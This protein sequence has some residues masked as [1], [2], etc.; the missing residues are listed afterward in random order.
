MYRFYCDDTLFFMSGVD[1]EDYY[2]LDAKL[3]LEKGK[4]GT[5]SFTLPS[6]NIAYNRINK[7]KSIITVLDNDEEIFRGRVL[8]DE[9]D[10]YNRKTIT[11]EGELAFLLD[12]IQRPYTYQGSINGFFTNLINNHN[13]QVDVNKKF[14]VG[15]ITVNDD[16]DYINR[17]STDY[18]NTYNVITKKL[19]ET[20]GG[21]LK[22][23]LVDGVRYID[24]LEEY[25]ETNEQVIEFGVN[26]LDIKEFITAEDIFT[27]LIPLGSKNEDTGERLTIESVNSGR[28]YL[29]ND[30]AIDLFGRIWATNTWE[31]VTVA[32]NL[33]TKAQ[34]YLDA[35]IEMSVT[36]TLKAI[37]LHLMNVNTDRI[38]EGDKLRVI[39]LPH[40]IDKYF[41]CTKVAIN[42]LDPS[43]NE[44]TFGST[45][46]TLTDPSTTIDNVTA[47]YVEQAITKVEE[48]TQQQ[49]ANV[50]DTLTQEEIMNIITNNGQVEGVY[51]VDG[52]IWINATYI[53]AEDLNA[54]TGKFTGE[55][56]AQSGKIGGIQIS[57]G[58]LVC[59]VECDNEDGF[60]TDG[61][62]S[63]GFEISDDACVIL[64]REYGKTE[65]DEDEYDG[66]GYKK[67]ALD[68]DCTIYEWNFGNNG[69][70]VSTYVEPIYINMSYENGIDDTYVYKG[71]SIGL[72]WENYGIL[73]ID[74]TDKINLNSKGLTFTDWNGNT[75]K[76]I[77]T[78]GETWSSGAFNA[79]GYVSS[80]RKIVYFTGPVGPRMVGIKSAKCTSLKMNIRVVEG[81]YVGEGYIDGGYDYA[82]NSNYT[83]TTYVR[84]NT[85]TLSI[86]VEQ[87]VTYGTTNNTPISID[88]SSATFKFS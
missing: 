15:N 9:K 62:T 16:N 13:S 8:Y 2:L 12:S 37:D 76:L 4:V 45:Y 51:L 52:Q 25:G 81:G 71:A 65:V 63:K 56:D 85:N 87:N 58:D 84:P 35:N 79:G 46:K 60:W 82:T 69:G 10:Y 68:S 42:P 5:L 23:R 43:N 74:A 78:A 83:I 20:N 3:T 54:I 21:Y 53:D 19:I 38:K 34:A 55:I 6:S 31:D 47:T 41:E 36:L 7:L 11:C 1:D 40:N 50:K 61:S 75:S 30:T 77:I 33:K 32:S 70:V 80:S 88:V 67:V 28:D 64:H 73:N 26:L 48:S 44:Y 18:D 22:T 72:D 86:K 29:E 24:Y 66:T 27:C 59:K 39:S 57:D 17:S 14:V 49:I